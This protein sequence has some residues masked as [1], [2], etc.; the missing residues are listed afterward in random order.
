[1]PATLSSMHLPTVLL[2]PMLFDVS[3][4]LH[5]QLITTTVFLLQQRVPQ[6]SGRFQAASCPFVP[7][8]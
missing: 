7:Q 6:V 4:T 5:P 2:C 3:S 8:Q 1:M